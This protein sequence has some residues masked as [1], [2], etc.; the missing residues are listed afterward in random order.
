MVVSISGIVL[1]AVILAVMLRANYMRIGGALTAA[2]FGFFLAATGA[3]P[4]ITGF[5]ATVASGIA[6][7]GRSLG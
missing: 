2:C 4:A 1:T 5:L 7:L 3:A 6:T